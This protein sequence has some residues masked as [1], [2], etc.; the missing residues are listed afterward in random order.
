[1]SADQYMDD[2][3]YTSAIIYLLLNR[4]KL[5]ARNFPATDTGFFQM[6]GS[7]KLNKYWTRLLA[8]PKEYLID[9]CDVLMTWYFQ[10]HKEFPS[11]TK[12]FLKN[13]NNLRSKLEV[14]LAY[15]PSLRETEITELTSAYFHN[16]PV[17]RLLQLYEKWITTGLDEPERLEAV[18]EL[19][20]FK[21]N[22][23]ERMSKNM[24]E[25]LPELNLRTYVHVAMYILCLIN[26]KRKFIDH[27]VESPLFQHV[28]PVATPAKVITTNVR[29]WILRKNIRDRKLAELCSDAITRMNS[30][31]EGFLL[32]K[33]RPK[34]AP[35]SN[36]AA[37]SFSNVRD[38]MTRIFG[39]STVTK[40][41]FEA[42]VDLQSTVEKFETPRSSWDPEDE[43]D[44]ETEPVF[45]EE[46]LRDAERMASEVAEE[47]LGY[48]RLGI[49]TDPVTGEKVLVLQQFPSLEAPLDNVPCHAED[50]S[51]VCVTEIVLDVVKG[52][53]EINPALQTEAHESHGLGTHSNAFEL[54]VGES[55]GSELL[56][57]GLQ[58]DD[59]GKVTVEVMNGVGGPVN[60]VHSMPGLAPSVEYPQSNVGLQSLELLG[61]NLPLHEPVKINGVV[62]LDVS[63]IQSSFQLASPAVDT[64]TLSRS[65][66]DE[67]L[68]YN[69]N[70]YFEAKNSKRDHCIRDGIS[71]LRQLDR[72]NTFI[73]FDF[74]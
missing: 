66:P 32:G 49:Y 61:G 64:G 44:D 67:H 51:N 2:E 52:E 43:W 59:V 40:D 15:C 62:F 6:C 57:S 48:R 68:E 35:T 3:L 21:G 9:R 22:F 56:G 18:R 36:Q 20:K 39:S 33:S 69:S 45:A 7:G 38:W 73:D 74:Q 27:P 23:V 72:G 50:P 42:A 11:M 70:L 31:P 14:K 10:Y 8:V 37:I 19:A 16:A 1:M 5:D 24:L 58:S 28:K 25:K 4:R 71:D 41:Q 65:K 17:R 12:H 30:V 53:T 29:K 47:V 63:P 60:E 34:T 54:S 55:H 26:F 13:P 46:D